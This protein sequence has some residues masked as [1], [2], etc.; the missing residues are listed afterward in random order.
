MQFH[1]CFQIFHH[2]LPLEIFCMTFWMVNQ[3][4]NMLAFHCGTAVGHDT[5]DFHG[6]SMTRKLKRADKDYYNYIS[7]NQ[8]PF[9][10]STT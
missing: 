3:A 4:E 9:T 8:W 5:H 6:F 10:I 7:S 2:L 1:K